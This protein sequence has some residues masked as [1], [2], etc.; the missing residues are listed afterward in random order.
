[1]TYFE[2]HAGWN[3]D[4]LEN[5]FI[6]VAVFFIKDFVMAELYAERIIKILISNNS[7]YVEGILSAY[8]CA[9]IMNESVL[10]TLYIF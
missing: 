1:M 3:V 5:M 2:K 4:E 6:D 9:L 7:E 8:Y 10:L